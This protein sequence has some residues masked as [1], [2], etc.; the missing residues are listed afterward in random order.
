MNTTMLLL[1]GAL[2]LAGCGTAA[3]G[4]GGLAM[5]GSGDNMLDVF[6]FQEYCSQ[7]NQGDGG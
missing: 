1:V 4:R 7:G 6:A 5:V 3:V 2:L